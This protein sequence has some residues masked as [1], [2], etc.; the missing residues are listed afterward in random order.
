LT[1]G[2]YQ[3]RYSLDYHSFH[4]GI[5]VPSVIAGALLGG[6]MADRMQKRWL[7]VI[8]LVCSLIGLVANA[9]PAWPSLGI[10]AAIGFGFG[11]GMYTAA[12]WS[13][14]LNLLPEGAAGR[15][16][17]LR[18][19]GYWIPTTALLLLQNRPGQEMNL[20]NATLLFATLFSF[21]ASILLVSRVEERRLKAA[22]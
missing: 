2:Y 22:D 17:G 8:G 4:Y 7:C 5:T 11:E 12:I 1:P 6:W 9:A 3:Y 20:S 14:L 13:L 16:M 19:A 10:V 21:A 18:A 15:F